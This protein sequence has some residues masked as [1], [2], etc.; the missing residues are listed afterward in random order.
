M[1]KTDLRVKVQ[2]QEAELEFLRDKHSLSLEKHKAEWSRETTQ[3][4]AN[5]KA[6]TAALREKCAQL[7][8]RLKD[9]PYA[10]LTDLLKA[11]AVKLPTLNISEL[12]VNA[13][14]K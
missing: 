2:V 8:V 12:S 13:K 11:L 1:T 14:G 10:Q 3:E 5:L 6:E 4:W 7:E 9:Q